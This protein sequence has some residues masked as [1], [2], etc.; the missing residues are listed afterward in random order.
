MEF[1]QD[2]IRAISDIKKGEE[3]T[4]SYLDGYDFY[5]RNRRIRQSILFQNWFFVCSC[6]VCEN[7]DDN[8]NDVLQELIKEVSDLNNKIC[9]SGFGAFLCKYFDMSRFNFDFFSPQ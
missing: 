1:D 5:M 7:E 2:E 3:I 4:I 6:D 8:N 9:N